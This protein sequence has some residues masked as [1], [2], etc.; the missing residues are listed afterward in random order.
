VW[1]NLS[2]KLVWGTGS[3]QVLWFGPPKL[4]FAGKATFAEGSVSG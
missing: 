1:A 4:V 3:V 2:Q